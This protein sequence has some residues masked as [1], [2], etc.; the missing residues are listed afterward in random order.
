MSSNDES[1]ARQL[2]PPGQP[3]ADVESLV[4]GTWIQS[5]RGTHDCFLGVDPCALA[6]EVENIHQICDLSVRFVT[7]EDMVKAMLDGGPRGKR[8]LTE[9]CM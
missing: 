3:S 8:A 7:V 9:A 2:P 1:G 6:R 4:S 5:E